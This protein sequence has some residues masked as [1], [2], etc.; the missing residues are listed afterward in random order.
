MKQVRGFSLIEA[1][2][3]LVLTAIG[4]LGIVAMQSRSIQYTQNSVERNTAIV[5]TNELIEIIRSNPSEVFEHVLPDYPINNS[6][7][8]DSIFFKAAGADFTTAADDCESP[9]T[10]SSAQELRDCWVAKAKTRLPEGDSLFNSD[11]YIC[12]SS[13]PG[14]CDDKGSAIEIQLA[15]S[16]RGEGGCLTAEGADSDVC[17]FSTRVEP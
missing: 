16:S 11:A 13:T 7:K 8:S 5:L 12:R 15:W 3:T 9:T 17:T 10:A 14:A 6:L 4:I 1:L 2:I